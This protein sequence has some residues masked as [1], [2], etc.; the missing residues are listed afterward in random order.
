MT[1][2]VGSSNQRFGGYVIGV[3]QIIPHENF[4]RFT[5]DF[6]YALIRLSHPLPSNKKKIKS[7]QL[8]TQD[9]EL[10]EG[11]H[12][13]VSGWGDTK[14]PLESRV[15]LRAVSVPYV[16]HVS[17][18]DAYKIVGGITEQMICAGYHEEG[19]KDACQGD[20]GGPLVVNSILYGVVSWGFGCAQPLYPGVYSKVSAVR[21][22][23]QE[24][25][26]I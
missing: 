23:I 19:G 16:D 18:D 12:C 25:T 13:F 3:S 26:G 20:S 10:V 11:T 21:D 24:K 8:P 7:V 2:H 6:D 14:N 5:I 1:A 22:W 15:I 9:E 17:C 4:N